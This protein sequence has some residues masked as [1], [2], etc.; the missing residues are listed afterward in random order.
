MRK[1]WTLKEEEYL[2]KWY[3]KKG[4]QFFMKNLNRT[5]E[6]IKK[7][8]QSMGLNAYVCDSL[9]VKTVA[10]CFHCHSSVIDNWITKYNLSFFK[11][12]RGQMTCKLI[13]QVTF[14]EWAE[15]H[16]HLIQWSKYEVGS[17]LPE[18]EWLRQTIREYSHKN[19]RKPITNQ[20]R[21]S[22]ISL[23]KRGYKSKEI[24]EITGR[25]LDSIKHIRAD[26]RK[27]IENG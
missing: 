12:I 11:V 1:D 20:D 27:G 17:I 14:W 4:V 21:L 26:Y 15:I 5:E 13:D 6:S 10:K 22:I 19:N 23:V 24:S 16:K 3:N 9:Y 2:E 18:P 7:K 8:A 25:T